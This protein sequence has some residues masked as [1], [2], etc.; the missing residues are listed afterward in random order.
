MPFTESKPVPPGASRV[1]WSELAEAVR[2]LDFGNEALLCLDESERVVLCNRGAEHLFGVGRRSIEGIAWGML[3]AESSR[4]TLR[5]LLRRVDGAEHPASVGVAA[6][7]LFGRRWDGSEF[8]VEG[9][10]SRLRLGPLSGYT[11][12]LRDISARVESETRLRWLAMYDSLTE[13]PNRALL[14][15]R[16]HSAIRRHRR[17]QQ[18]FALLFVDLDEFKQINDRHGHSIGDA[19][20]RACGARL[21]AA[22]RDSDTAARI[23]GDEFAIILEQIGGLI[24]AQQA[25][26]RIDRGL[27][28]APVVLDQ[29]RIHVSASIGLTLFPH[30][31]ADPEQ[32]LAR[33]DE[34]MYA[35]K[36]GRSVR[37]S[38]VPGHAGDE[39]D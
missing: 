20:L 39:H 3:L 25:I 7:E 5:D 37:L 21:K 17:N 8:P 31:G 24:D 16:L 29:A 11:L 12:L 18:A 28:D 23:G 36:R 1:L 4:G 35:I 9:S 33:A 32:L 26:E 6:G 27:R 34:A 19:V 2:L 10:L 13:L 38:A 15:D 22:L 30:G 14:M